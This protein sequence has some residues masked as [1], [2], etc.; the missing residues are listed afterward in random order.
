M[1]GRMYRKIVPHD[2]RKKVDDARRWVVFHLSMY[3][4]MSSDLDGDL[5]GSVFTSLIYGWGNGSWSA[6]PLY[7]RACIETARNAQGPVLECGS[8]LSTVVLGHVASRTGN[9]VYAIE[10]KTEWAGKVRA[11][12]ENYG[13]Q[14]VT[15]IDTQLHDYGDFVWYDISAAEMPDDFSMAVCDGPPGN[16]KGKRYGLMPVMKDRFSSDAFIL[17]DDIGR[18]GE[19]EVL[20]RWEKEEGITYT[21]QGGKEEQFAKVRL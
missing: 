3:R 9:S 21:V 20:G 16:V 10:H 19:Q 11:C 8:G 12:L 6:G 15:V 18:P 4:L 13:I 5:S 7:L 1:I 2:A 17:L 14:C